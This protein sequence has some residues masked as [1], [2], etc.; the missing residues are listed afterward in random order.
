MSEEERKLKLYELSG[1]LLNKYNIKH[2]SACHVC[3]DIKIEDVIYIVDK[4]KD[5]LESS[6]IYISRHSPI[7]N[8]SINNNDFKVEM[9]RTFLFIESNNHKNADSFNGHV[10][11]EKVSDIQLDISCE[12]ILSFRFFHPSLEISEHY[13]FR[14]DNN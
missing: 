5:L 8:F 2:N 1:Y 4:Y 9:C 3:F 14:D 10:E 13:S 12:T 7:G 11:L 6:N